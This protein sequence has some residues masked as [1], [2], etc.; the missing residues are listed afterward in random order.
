MKTNLN[1][2][3]KQIEPSAD[4]VYKKLISECTNP[5][6]GVVDDEKFDVELK[7][8]IDSIDNKIKSL[9]DSSFNVEKYQDDKIMAT[10]K[11]I[12]KD[13]VTLNDQDE[14]IEALNKTLHNVGEF[15]DFQ[16]IFKF[17]CNDKLL[18]DKYNID[19]NYSN[20]DVYSTTLSNEDDEIVTRVEKIIDTYKKNEIR[21]NGFLFEYLYGNNR[22]LKKGSFLDIKTNSD[23]P[24]LTV[25]NGR[26][27]FAVN[28]NLSVVEGSCM[29]NELLANLVV[30][31]YFYCLTNFSISNRLNMIG[32]SVNYKDLDKIFDSISESI[33]VVSDAIRESLLKQDKIVLSE[34]PIDTYYNDEKDFVSSWMICITPTLD[35]FKSVYYMY[36]KKIQS[37]ESLTKLKN[38]SGLVDSDW[39]R[40]YLNNMD[41]RFM[42]ALE[43]DYLKM[44]FENI[45]KSPK[46]TK[47]CDNEITSKRILRVINKIYYIDRSLRIKIINPNLGAENYL[48]DDFLKERKE[49][50]LIQFEKLK[51]L[52]DGRRI[53]HSIDDEIT[54]LLN[55][56]LNN[57]KFLIEY[58]NHKDLTPYATSSKR[59]IKTVNE[60]K[61]NTIYAS[62]DLD[63][64]QIAIFETVIQSANLN[65]IDIVK[66]LTYLFD[67]ITHSR[68]SD[69]NSFKY[70]PC[71]LLDE[72]KLSLKAKED[73]NKFSRT[74][75]N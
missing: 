62:S 20:I 12:I 17:A 10:D 23:N 19:E 56:I 25:K 61:F 46:C 36:R 14:Y 29:S 44:S 66:Y 31:K 24:F 55:Y 48:V 37:H 60:S 64:R 13:L 50:S 38:Y 75:D 32:F 15:L 9:S 58:L 28:N 74:I 52:A 72:V 39:M 7:K 45:I 5:A 33:E 41:H 57:Y 70:I 35:S 49:L 34:S 42:V 30:D 40:P 71:N 21:M 8:Y 43:L 67:E 69:N 68:L 1:K 65:D 59:I 73:T 53:Y 54:S 22:V 6:T 11:Q 47:G 27:E 2:N 3:S 63:S 51:K 26:I 16:T 4:N 18:R